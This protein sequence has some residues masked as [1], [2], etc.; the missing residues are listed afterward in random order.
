MGTIELP[1]AVGL[2][3]GA[4]RVH[5]VAKTA[6]KI[7]G[8]KSRQMI[9]PASSLRWDSARTLPPFGLWPRKAFRGDTCLCTPGTWLYRPGL[10][11][12]LSRS[13]PHA[14]LPSAELT[15]TGPRTDKRAGWKGKGKRLNCRI[16]VLGPAG[17][18]SEKAALLWSRGMNDAELSLR[19]F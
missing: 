6:V 15:S 5:P 14:W 11:A 12:T 2:V 7:L 8:V 18:Y 13:L 16:G 4:T 3:G 1:V 19:R 17:T 9:S 10:N